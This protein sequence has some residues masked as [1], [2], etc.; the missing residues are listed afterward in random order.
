MS[1]NSSKLQKPDSSDKNHHGVLAALGA[2]GIWGMFPLMFRL[3]DGVS[4][5][6]IVAH[7]VIWS[8]VFVGIILKWNNRMGEV[9]AALKDRKTLLNIG[10]SAAVLAL[11]WLVFIWAVETQRVVEVSLGYFINPLVNVTL[12]MVLLG[13]KQNRWQWLAIAIA[14]IAMIVQAIGMGAV[15][16]ISL[17]LAISFGFYG[18][19]RKT[20]SVGSAPGLFIETLLML[21]FAIIFL[22]YVFMT[23]GVGP[24]GDPKLL[25]YLVLTGPATAGALLIFAFAARRMRLTTLGMFQYIAPSMHFIIAIWVFN[26]PLNNIQLFSFVLIWI[27]IGVYTFDSA[28]LTGRKEGKING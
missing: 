16:I 17:T 5:P 12:G 24:H 20:V 9:T 1:Q 23:S 6:I 3:L 22:L 13:E 11:N 4:P 19:L 25:A 2:Y 7:R 26:E 18:Y 8:L 21:P 27:S 10:L 28:G 14:A 15:P